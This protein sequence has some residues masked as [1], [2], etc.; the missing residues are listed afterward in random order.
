MFK[1]VP[2][3]SKPPGASGNVAASLGFRHTLSCVSG[4]RCENSPQTSFVRSNLYA[5]TVSVML[6]VLSVV[7][8]KL[9]G[10]GEFGLTLHTIILVIFWTQRNHTN[11]IALLAMLPTLSL[12]YAR[13][14]LNHSRDPSYATQSHTYTIPLFYKYL[15]ARH[16]YRA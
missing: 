16:E 3:A 13:P 11:V 2:V 5:C 6:F 14:Q 10:R 15:V 8:G 7:L 4:I 9:I 12:I 1:A